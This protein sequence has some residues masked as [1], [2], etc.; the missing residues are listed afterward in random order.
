MPS[1][2]TIVF[3]AIILTAVLSYFIPQSLVEEGSGKIIF[4]AV[5]NNKG[6]ILRGKGLQPFG[7]WDVLMAP[8][9]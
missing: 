4:D 5:L 8:I 3:I 7:V 1:A 9:K 2:Y 6:E